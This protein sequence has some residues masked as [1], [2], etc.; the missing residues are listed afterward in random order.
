MTIVNTNILDVK[1]PKSMVLDEI[2][3]LEEEK[4]TTKSIL[5]KIKI[6]SK[7]VKLRTEL[8]NQ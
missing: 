5:E 2:K 4:Q 6:E 1:K 8:S 3:N 7:I